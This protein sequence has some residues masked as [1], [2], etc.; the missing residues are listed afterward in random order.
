MSKEL[1]FTITE[2]EREHL[3]NAI[4]WCNYADKMYL[5]PLLRKLQGE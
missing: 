1:T 2:E 4:Q 3:V 5:F